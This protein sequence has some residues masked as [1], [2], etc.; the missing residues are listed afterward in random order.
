MIKQYELSTDPKTQREKMNSPFIVDNFYLMY[1]NAQMNK[2]SKNQ[3][4]PGSGSFF[5][6]MYPPIEAII[7][8]IT[9][10]GGGSAGGASFLTM[11]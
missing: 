7:L 4:K 3:N 6:F 11:R 2:M 1:K 10:N 9:F 5:L 8:I